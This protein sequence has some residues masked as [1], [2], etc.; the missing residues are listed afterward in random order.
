MARRW[1]HALPPSLPV[2]LLVSPQPYV[3]WNGVNYATHGSPNDRDARV[4]ILF[5]GPGF[6]RGVSRSRTVRVVDIAPTLA[7]RIG[8]K[9]AEKLDGVV[10]SDAFR[11]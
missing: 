11:R 5:Y 4:P 2:V 3:Y 10:L 9:S 1:L 7:A 8:V 6:A